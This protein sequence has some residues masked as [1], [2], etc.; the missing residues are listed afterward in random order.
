MKESTKQKAEAF[1]GFVIVG[2]IIAYL[3]KKIF[4][5]DRNDKRR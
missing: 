3:L 5:D 1:I 4:G 2:T